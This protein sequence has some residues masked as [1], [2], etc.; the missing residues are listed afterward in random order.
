MKWNFVHLLK[1]NTFI[2]LHCIFRTEYQY[3]FVF[4]FV[5]VKLVNDV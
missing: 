1:D 2:L 5:R 4:I 3:N